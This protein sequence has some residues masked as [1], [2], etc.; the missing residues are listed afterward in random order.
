MR[1]CASGAER[2]IGS[3]A[4]DTRALRAVPWRD[5]LL[6]RILRRRGL[7]QGP[8]QRLIRRNPVT[9]QGPLLAIP[10]LELH[11]PAPL[12]IAAGEAERRDQALHP[13]RLE[14]LWCDGEMVEPP[15]H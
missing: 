5:A 6:L 1:R 2:P 13:Q 9:D 7:H 4:H 10:L 3:V 11:A 15:L 8:H 12:M 14:R